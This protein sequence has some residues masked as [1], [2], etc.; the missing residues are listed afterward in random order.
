M[1]ANSRFGQKAECTIY[2]IVTSMKA[3]QLRSVKHNE[4]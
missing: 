4:C 3:E 1:G 2:I